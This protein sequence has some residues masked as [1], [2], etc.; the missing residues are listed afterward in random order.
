M[1]VGAI[2]LKRIAGDV[3]GAQASSVLMNRIFVTLDETSDPKTAA[4]KVEKLVALFLGTEQAKAVSQS[5]KRV[6]G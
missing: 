4:A 3:I 1:S 2:E 6:L 5:F